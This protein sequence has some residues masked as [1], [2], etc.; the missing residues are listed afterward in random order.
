[1]LKIFHKVFPIF[2]YLYIFQVL[3]YNSGDFLQWFVRN[4]MQRNL[5]KKHKLTW[6]IRAALIFF[7]SVIILLI[8][9]LVGSVILNNLLFTPLFVI[10]LVQFSP[11][12]L[13]IS[14]FLILPLE[15]YQKNKILNQTRHKINNLPNLKVVAITGSFGKT[16]TKDILYTLLWKKY[17]IVKT[18][19]SFN[20]PLGISQTVLTD[21]KENTEVL[22]AEVG[23]YKKGEISNIAK[24][25]K[26]QI[27]VITAIAPQHLEKFGSIADIAQA[28]F[29]LAQNL[30]K[31][32]KVIL[33][34][35]YKELVDLAPTAKCDVMFYGTPDSEYNVED[36]KVRIDGTSFLI[37][38][39]GKNMQIKIP[40]I[41]VHHAYNFLAAAIVALDLGLTLTE[42]AQRANKLLPTPHRM[43]VTNT[44]KY[45]LIDNSFNTNLESSKSSFELINSLTSTQKIIITPGL[46]ELGSAAEKINKQFIEIGGKVADIVIIVGELNKRYLSE[47]LTETNFSKEKIFFASTTKSALILADQIAE[48]DSAILIENDLPDQYL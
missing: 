28:K 44:G 25:I 3:E 26:P 14:K 40:L 8:T 5:Q 23:A 46:I 43:E 17:R 18:P 42:I 4:P 22:I 36:A 48:K 15:L 27:G 12:Y 11:I 7:V 38:T 20:T 19:K 29:E 30:D 2:D 45:T 16:S 9:S 24:L 39:P 47:G 1:M 33:N 35:N 41:G 6:T 13:A 10:I 31:S 21:V 34:K 37:T 32:G